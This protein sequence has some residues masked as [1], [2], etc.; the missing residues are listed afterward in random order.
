M[1]AENEIRY[2]KRTK[3]LAN[4]C[5]VIYILLLPIAGYAALLS[6]M[7]FD[8]PTM[9]IPIGFIIMF[10]IVCVPISLL[11]SILNIWTQ[12]SKQQ[13]RRVQFFCL[14]PF[15]TFGAVFLLN[16]LLHILFL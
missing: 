16:A 2:K 4:I 14:L 5:T 6:P 10:L 15:Y 9:T 12:Y 8:K 1:I 3:Y 7:V 13:Y 11:I